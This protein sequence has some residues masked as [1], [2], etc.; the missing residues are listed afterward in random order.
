MHLDLAGPPRAALLRPNPTVPLPAPRRLLRLASFGRH[1]APRLASPPVSPRAPAPPGSHNTLRRH[2]TPTRALKLVWDQTQSLRGGGGDDDPR[3]PRG[4]LVLRRRGG[5]NHSQSG[6]LPPR[7]RPTALP[8][9][10]GATLTDAPASRDLAR[11]ALGPG[12]PEPPLALGRSPQAARGRDFD[13][14]P[15]AS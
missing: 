13:P 3:V 14:T 5:R 4:A 9:W 15:P 7:T 8:P 1:P 12:H 2:L 11:E 10:P 6:A